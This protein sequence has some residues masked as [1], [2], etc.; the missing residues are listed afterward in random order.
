MLA[1]R[2]E[3]YLVFTVKSGEPIKHG[4]ILTL[5]NPPATGQA[6]Y[7]GFVVNTPVIADITVVYQERFDDPTYY[8]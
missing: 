7:D 2:T 5:T 6:T 3:V 4:T 1:G 8:G